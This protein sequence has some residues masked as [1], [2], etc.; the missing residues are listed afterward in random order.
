MHFLYVFILQFLYNS[1]CFER[2]FRSSIAVYDLLYLQ[3]CTNH[4]L[5]GLYRAADTKSWIPDDERNCRSKYADLHKNCRIN[6]C[7]KCIL[8]FF[9]YNCLWCTVHTM[10]NSHLMILDFEKQLWL[11]CHFLVNVTYVFSPPLSWSYY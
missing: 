8:L 11:M 6:T 4:A 7:R 5:H 3:L 2:P 10:S 9:L 1:I